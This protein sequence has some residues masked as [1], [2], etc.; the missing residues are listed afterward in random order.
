M[1]EWA[2]KKC[3]KCEKKRIHINFTC[4]CGGDPWDIVESI[5]KEIAEL[6]EKK[7]KLNSDLMVTDNRIKKLEERV[8]SLRNKSKTTDN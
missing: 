2:Y 7:D 3:T 4:S 1:S 5:N 6:K 8:D